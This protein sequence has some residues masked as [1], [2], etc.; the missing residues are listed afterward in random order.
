MSQSSQTLKAA[1]LIV[2]DTASSDP[3]TDRAGSILRDAFRGAPNS[4]WDVV[5]TEIVPD[6][7]PGIQKYIKQW[8]DAAGGEEVN[9]IVTTGGT[10]FAVK[11]VTPEAIEPMLDKKAPGLMYMRVLT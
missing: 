3:S 5:H 7:I 4:P 6:S 9:L 11:D 8:S 1:L 10:G 2:S